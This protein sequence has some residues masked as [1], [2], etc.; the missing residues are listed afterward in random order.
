MKGNLASWKD[1]EKAWCPRLIELTSSL[2]NLADRASGLVVGKSRDEVRDI[3][4]T[5]V[6]MFRESYARIGKYT[7]EV[8]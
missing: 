8:K 4:R 1:V 5:E 6:R 7:P 2:D 3:L